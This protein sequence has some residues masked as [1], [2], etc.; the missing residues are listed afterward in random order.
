LTLSDVHINRENLV[1]Q[2]MGGDALSFPL[3]TEAPCTSVGMNVMS[4]SAASL[5]RNCHAEEESVLHHIRDMLL[6]A[7][8]YD[9]WEAGV[10][11]VGQVC[12]RA[13]YRYLYFALSSYPLVRILMLPASIRS[14]FCTCFARITSVSSP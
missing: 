8:K 13:T 14:I 6:Q 5:I 12:R 9:C 1:C 10:G 3:F 11:G 4:N 2:I 7:Q